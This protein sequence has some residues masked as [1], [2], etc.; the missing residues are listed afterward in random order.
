MGRKTRAGRLGTAAFAAAATFVIA[1]VCAISAQAGYPGTNGKIVFQSNRDGNVEIYTM[2]NDG[3]G[4]TRLTVNG[5]QDS[6][7]VWSPDG[8]KIAFTSSR[9]GNFEVY[10]M[11][12]DGSAQTRLTTMA[13]DDF[14]P[15]WSGDGTKIAFASR[16]DGNYEIYTMNANGTS[17]TRLTF[18]AAS[19]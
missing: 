12:A 14:Q 19:D 2:N 17:P 16:R 3:T 1:L 13:D 10:S 5:A 6:N 15:T 8:T 4:Q 9:D 11:N 7:P 18:N